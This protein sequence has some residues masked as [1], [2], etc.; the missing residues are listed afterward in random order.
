MKILRQWRFEFVD[1]IGYNY[2]GDGLPV[3]EKLYEGATP[4]AA[5]REF[6]R[7]YPLYEVESIQLETD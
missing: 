7:E 1:Y 2:D 5:L 4:W 6:R 3:R